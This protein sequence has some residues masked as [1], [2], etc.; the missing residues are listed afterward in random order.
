MDLTPLSALRHFCLQAAG[1]TFS[2]LSK[3]FEG[4]G[5]GTNGLVSLEVPLC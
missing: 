1:G 5:A 3:V 4:Q 2:G